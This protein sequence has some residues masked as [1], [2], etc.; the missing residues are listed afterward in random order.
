VSILVRQP[1]IEGA[2]RRSRGQ[3][4]VETAIVIVLFVTIAA[5]AVTFGYTMAV[6]NMISHSARDGAQMAATWP[7]RGVCG[8]IQNYTDLT[9]QVYRDMAAILGAQANS[10]AVNV[11]Q[12]PTPNGATPCNRPQTPLIGV[13]VQGCVPY[14]M[15]VPILKNLNILSGFLGTICNG[16]LGFSV[17]TTM[18]LLDEGV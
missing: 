15:P 10:L 13:N 17:N 9:S 6:A 12:T 2:R 3:A 7:N 16:Q 4:L 8:G 11:I 1:D 18:T 5:G 14:L